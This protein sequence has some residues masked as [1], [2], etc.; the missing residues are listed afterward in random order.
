MKYAVMI[1]IDGDWM[2]VPNNP[3]VFVNNPHPKLFDNLPDA[4]AERHK[5]NTG[6]VV[7]YESGHIVPKVAQE[8]HIDRRN[9]ISKEIR[10][11]DNDER[12]R[13]NERRKANDA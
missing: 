12:Q 13:A 10:P 11:F 8:W 2:Y 3:K 1:D 7:D 6:I 9:G 4:I 5:W